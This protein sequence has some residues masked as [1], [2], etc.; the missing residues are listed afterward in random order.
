[1]AQPVVDTLQVADE[2][3]RT[4]MG[5]EQAEGVART[6][7]TQLGEHVAVRKDVETGFEAMGARMDGRFAEVDARFAQ[8]DARFAQIDA[9]FEQVEARFVQ[10]D[11]RFVQ[12]EAKMDRR[13]GELEAGIGAR[14]DV[15]GARMDALG[16]Q[17]KFT[18]AMSGLLVAMFAVGMGMV[19]A[20]LANPPAPQP[21][22][23]QL[24]PTAGSATPAVVAGDAGGAPPVVRVPPE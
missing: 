9:R 23:L 6:L 15:L 5:H 13:F 11:A 18:L 1:M 17:L 8:V 12:L 7:G 10:I 2:L 20:L 14:M 24:P 16:S 3:R 19:G 22:I 21:I 4:G